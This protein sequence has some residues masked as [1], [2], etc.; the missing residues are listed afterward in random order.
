M[1]YFGVACD[2]GI[3]SST[4]RSSKPARSSRRVLAELRHGVMAVCVY[5]WGRLWRR[6]RAWRS[7]GGSRP[8]LASW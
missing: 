2:S 5:R 8:R 4:A 6:S 3:T 7:A 1:A